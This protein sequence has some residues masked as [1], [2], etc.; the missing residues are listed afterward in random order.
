MSINI[1]DKVR[2]LREV[3]GGVVT[4]FRKGGF[5]LVEDKDGFEIPMLESDLVVIPEN[6]KVSPAS[7]IS[8]KKPTDSA[9][10]PAQQQKQHA[11]SGAE[12]KES[13]E[14][15][16]CKLERMVQ[17][18]SHRI[19]ELEAANATESTCTHDREFRQRQDTEK[20]TRK[21]RNH[22]SRF[23]CPCPS[24]QHLGIVQ[25]R[26]QRLPDENLS[27]YDGTIPP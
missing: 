9:Y 2:F 18:L 13:L 10:S 8:K 25:H 19:D 1:G 14:E 5:I 23:A 20:E 24:G 21:R 12:E 16:L 4:G 7:D 3:G 26:N 6:N 22:R 17:K 27:R 11:P 15:R